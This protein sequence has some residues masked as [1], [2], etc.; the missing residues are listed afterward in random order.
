MEDLKFQ[1][2]QDV[3]N[4]DKH[5]DKYGFFMKNGT[6]CV[7]E[8][9]GKEGKKNTHI[10]SNFVAKCEYHLDNGTNNS[11]RIIR[12]QHQNGE[13]F[14]VELHSS[15]MKLDPFETILKSHQCTFFGNAY[16]LKR[17]FAYLMENEQQASVIESLG[18]NTEHNV[19][20]FSNSIFNADGTLIYVNELGIINHAKNGANFYLPAHGYAQKNNPDYDMERKFE[21][22]EG[23]LDFEEWAQLFFNTYGKNGSIAILFLI[24]ALFWDVVFKKVC[25]FPYL[26][27]FGA[28]GTGKTS[29]VEMLLRSF[30]HDNIGIP[31][32]N[33]TPVALSRTI[34]SRNN[35]IFY[36]KEYTPEADSKYQSIL[37]SAYDGS[38]RSTGIKS[39]DNKTK[40][41]PPRSA[42]ILDGNSLPTQ[43]TAVLSRMILLNF[44]DNSFSEKQVTAFNKL[45][46]GQE[47]GLGKVLTD[48]LVHRK[49]FE[50]EFK[51]RFDSSMDEIRKQSNSDFPERTK[52]H[53]ALLVTTIKL[54]STK[55]KFPFSVEK[56]A[57]I[58]LDNSME[59]NHLMRHSNE[60]STFWNTLAF[61]IKS[62][63]LSGMRDGLDKKHCHFRVK[64]NSREDS[65]MQIKFDA[66]YPNYV[67]YCKNN[68]QSNLDKS[69]LKMLLT[70]KSYHAFIPGTQKGRGNSY[71][72]SVFGSCLQ[73]RLEVS[74]T[75]YY[76]DEVEIDL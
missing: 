28:F 27:L 17:I 56:V 42:I 69:S 66:V 43:N 35:S 15:D 68:S 70:S 73:F 71:T 60:L 63:K 57:N 75:G 9:K 4:M 22:Q 33:I 29:L 74:D 76:I 58:V 7:Y 50:Q 47:K 52:K 51:L 61:G 40:V 12:L 31:L 38:G 6:Y 39:N 54:L 26:F 37:L 72:D 55:L 21:Y 67:G 11:K 2:I 23:E 45:K 62:G 34:A 19:Y 48:I 13:N 32:C 24:L 8:Y 53:M 41:S 18:Y 49:Y 64:E 44:E 16:Q 65:I 20:A 3:L 5:M 1:P 36:L 46:S 10:L 59:Q 25:F 14:I 30:G